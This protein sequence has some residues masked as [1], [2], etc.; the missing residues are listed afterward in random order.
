MKRSHNA[1]AKLQEPKD[2]EDQDSEISKR[3]GKSSL[4]IVISGPTHKTSCLDSR[5]GIGLGKENKTKQ[6]KQQQ[7]KQTMKT[8]RIHTKQYWS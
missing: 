8:K 1:E 3:I 4:V 6:N 7:Q 2:L 5:I